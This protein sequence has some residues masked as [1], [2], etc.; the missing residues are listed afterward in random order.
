MPLSPSASPQDSRRTGGPEASARSLSHEAT[1]RLAQQPGRQAE[2]CSQPWPRPPGAPPWPPPR[3]G[4][5]PSEVASS[6]PPHFRLERAACGA[7]GCEGRCLSQFQANTLKNHTF[8]PILFL[9]HETSTSQPRAAVCSSGKRRHWDGTAA[10]GAQPQQGARVSV[11][12][13]RREPRGSAGC[14]CC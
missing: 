1:R 8:Q 9:G 11:V 7:S 5:C 2:R 4:L 12:A 13:C 10:T 6:S 14:S 3:P